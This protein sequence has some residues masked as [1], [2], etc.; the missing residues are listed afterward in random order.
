MSI[1]DLIVFVAFVVAVVSIGLWK[2]RGEDLKGEHAAS[3]YFLAG[4]GLK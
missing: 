1:P 3:D 2:S 4:R